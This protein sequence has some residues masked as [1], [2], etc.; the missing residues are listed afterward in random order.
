VRFFVGL[1]LLLLPCAGALADAV[2]VAA[3]I[4][5][6]DALTE[7]STA[8]SSETDNRVQFTFGSSGQLATQVKA[9][10][11][12]DVFITAAANQADLLIRDGALNAESRRVVAGN[13]LVLIVPRGAPDTI[14]GF[15]SLTAAGIERVA[16]GDPTTVPAGQYARECLRAV[17]LWDALQPRLLYGTNV[18]AVLDFVSRGEV[19]AGIVYRTDALSAGDAVR[20][21]ATA[22]TSTHSPIEYVGAVTAQP[23]H[24]SADRFLEFLVRPEGR[25]ILRRHGF[26]VRDD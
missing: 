13:A 15:D 1:L 22:E 10:A 26:V 24:R 20:V 14:K 5:M 23:R 12:I 21:V 6:K 25:A 8:F 19:Q 2:V 4:S 3:A 18:R 17:K 9:G 7:A 11:P 16:I